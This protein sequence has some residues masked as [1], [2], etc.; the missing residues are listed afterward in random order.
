MSQSLKKRG[1]GGKRRQSWD[2]SAAGEDPS[3]GEG[4]E[5]RM[6]YIERHPSRARRILYVTSAAT[7]GTGCDG[8]WRE[9]RTETATAHGAP[10]GFVDIALIIVRSPFAA[11]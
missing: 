9:R 4:R 7:D 8:G 6:G 11:G 5:R 10:P 1:K 3:G 2:R